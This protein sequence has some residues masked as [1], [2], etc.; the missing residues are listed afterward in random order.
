MRCRS[1]GQ[2]HPGAEGEVEFTLKVGPFRHF[3][4]KERAN[5]TRWS[6]GRGISP[7]STRVLST[8]TL[9]NGEARDDQLAAALK[10]LW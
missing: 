4:L 3:F 10:R 9:S 7:G 6:V 1:A 5:F 2:R 8:A